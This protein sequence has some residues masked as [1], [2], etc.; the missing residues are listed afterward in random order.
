M[1]RF[2]RSISFSIMAMVLTV[3]TVTMIAASCVYFVREHD[4][5]YERLQK[6]L[7]GAAAQ[8][9][10]GLAVP[11]WNFD[12]YQIDL[13]L[14]GFMHDATVA[15]IEL[16]AEG[17]RFLRGRGEG[18]E[19][20]RAIPASTNHVIEV[21]RPVVFGGKE[22]GRIRIAYTQRYIREE[23]FRNTGIM[24]AVIL[25]LDLAI[26]ASLYLIL[27]R[28]LLTPLALLD[29]FAGTVIAGGDH[30][31]VLPQAK[32]HGEL[33]TLRDSLVS[34]VDTLATRY[35]EKQHAEEALRESENRLQQLSDNLSDSVVYQVDCG[36]SGETRRFTYL[37]A[38]IERLHGVSAEAVMA[39]PGI[40][41]RQ[42]HEGDRERV[43]KAE[44]EA[45]VSL[46]TFR[47]EIRLHSSDGASRWLLL[48]S[49]P[50]RDRRGHVILDGIEIDVT[51]RRQLEEQLQQAQKMES[52]GRL[53]GGV[54]H[55][56]NNMLGVILG[57]VHLSL[58]KGAEGDIRHNLMM[59]QQAAERSSNITRQ[60]LAF[61]RKQVIVPKP[62]N[63]NT[64]ILE[65][66]KNLGRLIGEDVKLVF[67][68]SVELWNVLID[69]S[70]VDQILMNLSV[71]ARDAMPNG[72]TLTIE[73][74]NVRIDGD[75]SHFHPDAAP[76]DYIQLSISD[77]GCGMNEEIREHI[78]EPFF[79]TKGVGKGTGLGL[80]MVYGIVTQNNGF[81]NCYSEPGQGSVFRLYL[82]R[83]Q[84]EVAGDRAPAQVARNGSGTILLVEDEEM[85]LWATTRMLEDLGYV[86]V[87]ASSPGQALKLCEEGTAFDLVLTDVVM[88]GI[89]GRE[90]AERI[91][92]MRPGVKVL[93]MSGYT[94]DLVAQRGIIEE[95]MHFISKP[96][97]LQKLS[98]I[99]HELMQKPLR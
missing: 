86:V 40:L 78:F 42:I 34:M 37:S 56:F 46:E 76:G 7:N 74:A 39:D 98:E 14:D 44:A 80:A 16:D 99:L 1:T 8:L 95:G 45:I 6:E 90:M 33:G 17:Q 67:R 32:F 30:R 13:F 21:R 87:Q 43:A 22:I 94:A 72:G 23:L 79:T 47:L 84:Q 92:E 51:E 2:S 63:L 38:G 70:Q 10:S 64:F 49:T 71:N 55:D 20:I 15:Y 59:I 9:A 5:R 12:D 57:A 73:T 11:V 62:V 54:A 31:S 88:P 53:A 82:P 29:Q 58:A 91:K 89:N 69:P 26:C 85:L 28:W 3:V 60:L 52:V 93:F 75:Y 48:T 19:A 27:S 41:Y 25:V 66:V 81:L 50:H 65:S 61:S 24:L 77:T 35:L 97:D 83:L 36:V 4:V 96:L 68:P 18:W